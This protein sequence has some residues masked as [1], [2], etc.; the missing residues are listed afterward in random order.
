MTFVCFYV[1][2][3]LAVSLDLCK[4]DRFYFI[5]VIVSN[6]IVTMAINMYELFL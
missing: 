3:L 6:V 5:I 4:C 1:M 2:Y